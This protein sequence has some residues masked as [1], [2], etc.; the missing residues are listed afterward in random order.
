VIITCVEPN[1]I[2]TLIPVAR[3]ILRHRER[4][5]GVDFKEDMRC[6]IQGEVIEV[7][8]G[9]QAKAH[10][11]GLRLAQ[12]AERSERIGMS[13]TSWGARNFELARLAT[14]ASISCR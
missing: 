14:A 4:V 6:E 5:S 13:L 2:R 3:Y 8:H 10:K 11:D 1:V 9:S 12:V 7:W